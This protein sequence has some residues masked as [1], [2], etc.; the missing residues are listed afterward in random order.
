MRE[1]SN[2]RKFYKSNEFISTTGNNIQNRQNSENQKVI[3]LINKELNEEIIKQMNLN[4]L[5]EE[6]KREMA[7]DELEKCSEDSSIEIPHQMRV[8]NLKDLKELN[9]L[10]IKLDYNRNIHFTPVF[11]KLKEEMSKINNEHGVW[12]GLNTFVLLKPLM[13]H[14]HKNGEECETHIR[15]EVLTNQIIPFLTL[16]LPVTELKVL[17]V[18]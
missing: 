1:R 8:V 16:D 12:K 9:K 11:K 4:N 2:G 7:N 17:E 13:F 6:L 18:A 10:S 14:K 3:D 5:S 15:C